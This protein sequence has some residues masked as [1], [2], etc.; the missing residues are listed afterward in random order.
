MLIEC[1]TDMSELFHKVEVATPKGKIPIH[2]YGFSHGTERKRSALS[3][4]IANA[5]R[6]E[7]K[8]FGSNDYLMAEGTDNSLLRHINKLT[9]V[10]FQIKVADNFMHMSLGKVVPQVY[11]A[12]PIEHFNQILLASVDSD[13]KIQKTYWQIVKRDVNQAPANELEIASEKTRTNAIEN[14]E[15]KDG[16]IDA[17]CKAGVEREKA[18]LFTEAQTTF[19]SLLMA[20]A[21]YHRTFATGQPTRLFVGFN[22]ANEV[23]EFLHD[24]EK[25]DTYVKKLHPPLKAMYDFSESHGWNIVSLFEA[26][27]PNFDTKH[28]VRLYKWLALEAAKQ[29]HTHRLGGRASGIINIADFRKMLPKTK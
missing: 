17:L 24:K 22:H 6:A 23:E 4:R 26:H 28:H 16:L 2:V 18:E 29:E 12:E 3:P 15:S 20:R 19:R 13:G 10:K 5:L 21:A 27:A 7:A 14:R 11:D 1:E 8:G 25:L 9:G